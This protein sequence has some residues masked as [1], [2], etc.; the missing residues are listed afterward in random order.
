MKDQSAMNSFKNPILDCTIV[1]LLFLGLLYILISIPSHNKELYLPEQSFQKQDKKLFKMIVNGDGLDDALAKVST[2]NNTI[3]IAV[4]NKAYVE[5]DKPML[6]LF[7]DGFWDG[8]NTRSLIDH[9]LIVAVDQTSFDRCMFLRLYC[10]KLKTDGVDYGGGEVVYM[11]EDF[12]KMMWTRTLF[13]GQ[14]LKRGYNFIFT[15]L[16]LIWLFV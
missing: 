9:L 14:V 1:T 10:Y 16:D 7:L 6:D 8:E 2:K 12:I 5:G 13:L 15:D 4:I 11:S 3:I